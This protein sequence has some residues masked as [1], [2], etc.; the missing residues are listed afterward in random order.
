MRLRGIRIT[1]ATLS[2]LATLW[3]LPAPAAVAATTAAF[4]DD[5]ATTERVGTADP[6][7]SAI[8]ISQR[9]FEDKSAL[10]VVLAGAQNFADAL[11]GSPLTDRG[12]L[13][14]TSPAKLD[15]AVR[16]ELLRVLGPDGTV[17]LLGGHGALSVAVEEA[18]RS[19]GFAPR[20]LSGRS[21]VETAVVAATEVHRLHPAQTE[22]LLARSDDW[23]DS[24]TGGVLAARSG[25]PLLVTPPGALHPAV[26]SALPSF[27]AAELTVLGGESGVSEAAESSAV[28]AMEK[29]GRSAYSHR[30]EGPNRAATAAAIAMRFDEMNLTEELFRH[31]YVLVNGYTDDGWAHALPAAGFAADL[32]T[33]V[34]LASADDLPN[35][36]AA[37][38]DGCNAAHADV[39]VVGAATQLGSAA[40]ATA[41][42]DDSRYLCDVWTRDEIAPLV[43]PRWIYGMFPTFGGSNDLEEELQDSYDDEID[44]S[45]M[46]MSDELNALMALRVRGRAAFDEGRE[47]LSDEWPDAEPAHGFDGEAYKHVA[48]GLAVFTVYDGTWTWQVFGLAML[49]APADM[50]DVVEELTHLL[51]ERRGG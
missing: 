21:R 49:E 26:E 39:V 17:Y 10:R 22:L 4:D 15:D 27:A 7:T 42:C 38:V 33:P 30:I 5:P 32:D 13:L 8:D 48:E 16:T 24:V 18:V 46:W 36:T 31:R 44:G 6:I 9:R 19:A 40:D 25:I 29:G 50:E 37:L 1:A 3:A 20:R 45:C 11:A 51:L 35:E 14:L 2:T 47:D 12:P 34:L 23:V 41:S 28:R 43:R